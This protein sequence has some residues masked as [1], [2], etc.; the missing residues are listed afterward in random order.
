MITYHRSAFGLNLLMKGRGS[1]VYRSIVPS[2]VG[3]G[4]FFLIGIWYPVGKS[5]DF[6]ESLGHRRK[7]LRFGVRMVRS[8]PASHTQRSTGRS[9]ERVHHVHWRVQALCV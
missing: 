8:V 6:G 7:R 3:V 9:E 2:L 4:V 1:A 5:D